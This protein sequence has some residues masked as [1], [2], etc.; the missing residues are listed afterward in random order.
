MYRVLGMFA[1]CAVGVLSQTGP[2][3][4]GP[5]QKD[6]MFSTQGAIQIDNVAEFGPI[7]ITAAM[8]GPMSTVAG[9]PYSAQAVTERVQTLAD[10]NRIVQ[11]TS[12]TVA[13][14]ARGRIRREE[15]LPGFMSNGGDGP[16]LTFIEDPVA[17]VHWT[18]DARTKTAIKMP[19][20]Q[21]KAGPGR[22]FMPPPVG[23]D[24]T[25]FVAGAPAMPAGKIQVIEN[26]PSS[27]D[28]HVSKTDLG[29]Q[30]TEGVLAQGT[31]VTR[32]IPAGD[33]GNEQPIVIT[34]ETWYSP[35]LKV[36]VMSKTTDP[37]MGDTTYKLTN[38][39][40]SEPDASLFQV[41]DDY[42]VKDQ[43]TNTFVY[44]EIKKRP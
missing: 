25:W 14:D 36:L 32:T 43:P 16:H 19:F 27:P 1:A 44:R 5:S 37:R 22:G 20:A 33:V 12:G 40:R 23:P 24:K 6:V 18:L 4:T 42:T 31:R 9:A 41:P 38:I 13:R 7:G 8:A 35:E 26:G 10:G 29:T 39:V 2:N 28:S 11:S 3:Q 15:S 30:N 17:G 21:M 34:T